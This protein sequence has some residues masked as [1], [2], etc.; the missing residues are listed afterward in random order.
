MTAVQAAITPE[1]PDL[2]FVET[3]ATP[4][5]WAKL[6]ASGVTAT[7]VEYEILEEG[8]VDSTVSASAQIVADSMGRTAAIFDGANGTLVTLD[9]ETGLWQSVTP[10][11]AVARRAGAALSVVGSALYV[12]GGEYE[13]QLQ[14]DGWAIDLF[15][16]GSSQVVTGLPLRRDARV[17]VRPNGQTLLLYGGTDERGRR[18]DDIWKINLGSSTARASQLWSDTSEASRFDPA[19]TTLEV[20]AFGDDAIKWVVTDSAPE[21]LVGHER[22]SNGWNPVGR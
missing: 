17:G 5:R 18:H 1:E 20:P 9:A 8:I 12:L 4:T 6:R 10:P 3:D 11:A 16:A 7:N 13:R 22:G 19:T 21:K 14:G 2:L 15:G